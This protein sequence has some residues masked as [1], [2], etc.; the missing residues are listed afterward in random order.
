LIGNKIEIFEELDSTNNY[1][2]INASDLEEGSI[3]VAKKQTSGRGRRE[4]KW[5]SKAGNLYFSF[6]LKENSKRESI[7]KYIVQSSVAIIRT[8]NM[9][10]ISASIKYPNDCLVG[11]KKIA[12]I[13]I[14]SLGS[15][16]LDYVI[17]GIG[18]NINQINFDELNNKAISMKLMANIE[19]NVMD[20]LKQFIENYNN[21]L[22]CGYQEVFSEYIKNSIVLNM[23][24]TYEDEVY[25]IKEILSDGNIL[26]KNKLH[27]HHVAFSE[28]S[29]REIY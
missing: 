27:E 16:K 5:K 11:N 24:I 15:S 1:I 14:E 22:N 26:I 9:F 17:I 8:L 20:V 10:S 3:I 23:S 7:F 29:L 28:I 13:L 6:I 21:I 2:K 12:G 19:Y 4:N 18:I 25:V